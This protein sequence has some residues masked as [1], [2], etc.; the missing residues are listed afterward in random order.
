MKAV[1]IPQPSVIERYKLRLA[2][3]EI[4]RTRLAYEL[5][6]SLP[7]SYKIVPAMYV[8]RGRRTDQRSKIDSS[9]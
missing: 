8:G 5:D 3:G 7:T 9:R 4:T 6:V 1:P 2:A